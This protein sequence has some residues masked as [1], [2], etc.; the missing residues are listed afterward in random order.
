MQVF[1]AE[2]YVEPENIPTEIVQEEDI[3]YFQ[4]WQDNLKHMICQMCIYALINQL[5]S[6]TSKVEGIRSLI[7]N[8]DQLRIYLEKQQYDII[9]I[10][11][12]IG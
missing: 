9:C 3:F 12:T 4:C 6:F 10:N 8:I 1:V 7:K 5:I 2:C 11:E